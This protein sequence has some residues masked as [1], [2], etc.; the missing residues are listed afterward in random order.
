MS[1]RQDIFDPALGETLDGLPPL[2]RLLRCESV[3]AHQEIAAALFDRCVGLPCVA[4]EILKSCLLI[5]DDDAAP[6]L[7]SFSSS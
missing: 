2:E 5:C 4:S 3:E 6:L 7:T 1:I